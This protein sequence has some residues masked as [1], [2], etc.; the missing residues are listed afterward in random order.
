MDKEKS[1]QGRN[2]EKKSVGIYLIVSILIPFI[3]AIITLIGSGIISR[4]AAI[5]QVNYQLKQ[6]VAKPEMHIQ[7]IVPQKIPYWLSETREVSVIKFISSY[8]EAEESMW[9]LDKSKIY[10]LGIKNHAY[11]PITKPR[12]IINFSDR[13]SSYVVR[14]ESFIWQKDTIETSVEKGRIVLQSQRTIAPKDSLALLFTIMYRLRANETC[15]SVLNKPC[16]LL[17][18]INSPNCLTA[19]IDSILIF[20]KDKN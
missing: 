8:E 15:E 6:N 18:V 16:S 11:I 3:I 13:F 9:C 10:I 2:Q 19:R 17:C 12:L 14:D 4:N 7:E 1:I 5:N 20:K